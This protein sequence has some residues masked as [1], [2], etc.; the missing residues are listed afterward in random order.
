MEVYV[1]FSNLIHRL[2]CLL[3]VYFGLSASATFA[4]SFVAKEAS[5]GPGWRCEFDVSTTF[6]THD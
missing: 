2:S 6:K 5:G 4:Q 1:R 3:V